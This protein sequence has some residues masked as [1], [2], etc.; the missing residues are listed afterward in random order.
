M[1]RTLEEKNANG[2]FIIDADENG[3]ISVQRVTAESEVLLKLWRGQGGS[4]KS[5]FHV[6]DSIDVSGFPLFLNRFSQSSNLHIEL[7]F[8]A[9]KL[10]SS[11]VVLEDVGLT[12]GA[13]LFELLTQR[14][15]TTG[16]NGAGSSIQ[17]AEDFENDT[18]SASISVEGRKFLKIVSATDIDDM[19]WRLMLGAKAFDTVRSEDIDDFFDALAGGMKGSIFLH[20]RQPHD[21]PAVFWDKA[22]DALGKA[23]SEAFEPNESR[24]GL[25]PGVKATLF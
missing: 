23:L 8:S 9:T 19:R 18:V 15:E 11:H 3:L 1:S 17:S 2:R 5:E 16:V 10:S 14:M 24:R 4:A 7:S 12:I 13:A 21:D 6:A 22:I 25:P 20:E